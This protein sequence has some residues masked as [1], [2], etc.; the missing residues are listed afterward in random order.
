LLY[1]LL[2]FAALITIDK[3]GYQDIQEF[4]YYMHQREVHGGKFLFL[5]ILS[6]CGLRANI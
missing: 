5:I 2:R 4:A 3:I 6:V 1:A